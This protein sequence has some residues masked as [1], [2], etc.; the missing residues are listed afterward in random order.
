M[1]TGRGVGS[2]S[3]ATI[4]SGAPLASTRVG[5]DQVDRRAIEQPI[6]IRCAG[7]I[8]A[9]QA[10]VAEDPPVAGR[11]R[12][13]GGGPGQ[14]HDCPVG[15]VSGAADNVSGTAC[16]L[17]AAPDTKTGAETQFDVRPDGMFEGRLA[18]GLYEVIILTA[19]EP[20][21]IPSVD[22]VGESSA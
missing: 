8:A 14:R 21:V 10:V 20:I 6:D 15:V 5:V 1:Y 11:R 18:P 16:V 19:S 4:V 13:G 12:P 7:R 9:K 22:A 2:T 17:E 3:I